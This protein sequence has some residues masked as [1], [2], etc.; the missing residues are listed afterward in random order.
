MLSDVTESGGAQQGVDYGV[1][2]NIAVAV[3][4]QTAVVRN[5][6]AAQH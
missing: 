2:Q 3:T 5:G 1:G 6:H 4:G